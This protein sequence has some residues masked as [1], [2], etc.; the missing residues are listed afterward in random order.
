MT[1]IIN[2]RIAPVESVTSMT[3]EML[4]DIYRENNG[5]VEIEIN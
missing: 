5:N 4:Q 3:Y 2:Y 1:T